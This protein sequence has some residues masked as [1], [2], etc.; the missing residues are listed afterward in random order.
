MRISVEDLFVGVAAGDAADDDAQ[1]HA[2]TLD[3]RVA[4]MNGRVNHDSVAPVHAN[5]STQQ[6]Q[7]YTAPD[8]SDSHPL[9]GPRSELVLPADIFELVHLGSRSIQAVW[10]GG[11]RVCG[12]DWKM[13]FPGVADQLE[14][15]L[16]LAEERLC[17]TTCCL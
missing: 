9:D 5:T 3:A 6:N 4:M 10:E 14:V 1:G 11:R 17:Y 12:I 13:I 16:K 15:S 2:R 8:C 7:K